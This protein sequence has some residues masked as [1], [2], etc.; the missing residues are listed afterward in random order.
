MAVAVLNVDKVEEIVH[1]F[2]QHD[3]YLFVC[4]MIIW[5]FML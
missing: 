1:V 4:M 2:P 5:V 3:D